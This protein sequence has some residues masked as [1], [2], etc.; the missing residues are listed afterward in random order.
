MPEEN[1]FDFTPFSVGDTLPEDLT[2]H[3][4]HEDKDVEKSLKDYSGK[5]KV[6]FFYP[7]D[8]SFVCPTELEEM[9]DHY[10]DF[11][12]E[13]AEIFAISTDSV[14]VH[15]AWKDASPAIQKVTFPMVADRTGDLSIMFNTYVPEEGVSLRGTFLIN[16]E[17]EIILAEI[18]NRG[19]G[20]SAKELLRKLKAAR[21]V[22]EHGDQVCPAS[23]E[24]GEETLEPGLDLV[25]KI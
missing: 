24:P 13:N 1:Q 8:F 5:W 6:F 15:K 14:F 25:G 11:T 7:A 18:G 10:A 3:M 21:F 12:A 16:P 20:R 4:F 2:L 17:N 19:V 9:A 22:A 23:W